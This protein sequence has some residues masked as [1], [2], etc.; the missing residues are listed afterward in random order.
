M[1]RKKIQFFEDENGLFARIYENGLVKTV[2]NKKNL[3]E[4]I[5]IAEDLNARIDDEG[6]VRTR[7]NSIIKEYDSYIRKNK[8]RLIIYNLPKIPFALAKAYPKATAIVVAAA[9]TISGA[10]AFSNHSDKDVD[11][12]SEPTISSE[13]DDYYTV[14][15]DITYQTPIVLNEVDKNADTFSYESIGSGDPECIENAMQYQELFN[16]YGEMYGV[17]PDLL[18][19]IAAQESAGNHYDNIGNG[20]AEGIMQIEKSVHIGNEVHAYNFE[21]GEYD[22]FTVTEESLQDLET[23][24]RYGAMIWADCLSMYDGNI[25]LALQAY[26]FGPGNM[27]TVLNACSQEEGVSVDYIINNPTYNEWLNYR[28]YVSVGDPEYVENVFKF[29]P[30]D[31]ELSVETEEGTINL[32]IHKDHEKTNQV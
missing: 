21:T 16:K 14:P 24:I 27:R 30:D 20:P 11:L 32:T 1:N 18:I 15:D 12:S 10:V 25:P 22:R 3:R 26:N 17:D 29:L 5:S 13:L 19:A 6:L 7:T 9:M 28:N 4:L 8:I 23:N 2:R 31:E